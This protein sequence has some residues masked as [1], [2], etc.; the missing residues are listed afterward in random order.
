M[1]KLPRTIDAIVEQQVLRWEAARA[2]ER[3]PA[4]RPCPVITVSRS[5]G[6]QGAALAA[7]LAERTGFELWNQEIVHEVAKSAH[8]PERLLASLDEHRRNAV[9]T[10][11]DAFGAPTGGEES[12]FRH[13]LSFLHTLGEHGSAVIVGRGAHYALD[14]D[15]ALRVRVDAP[16]E[17]R[18]TSLAA[19]REIP[20]R[21]ARKQIEAADAER[22]DFMR[23]YY[24]RRLDDPSTFDLV[25]NSATL[26]PEGMVEVVLS[27]YG[28]RF[29]E[30][31]Q[32][33]AHKE[34]RFR[35]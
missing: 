24:N 20:E 9:L 11:L 34:L 3:R 27:A 7:A 33:R 32:V 23:Q 35:G 1:S 29:G 19:R 28:A 10:V 25:L 16:L 2:K 6:S 4:V 12:Y 21:E 30:I 13:L 14:S 17:H 8:L 5:F 22:R 26:P 18:V 15:A 31:P